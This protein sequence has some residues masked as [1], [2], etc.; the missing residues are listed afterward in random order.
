MSLKLGELEGGE[1]GVPPPGGGGG[2][3]GGSK[4]AR[5]SLPSLILMNVTQTGQEFAP[6]LGES[7]ILAQ[8]A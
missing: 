2:G 7:A 5:R 8:F 3:W 6:R 1:G 4:L